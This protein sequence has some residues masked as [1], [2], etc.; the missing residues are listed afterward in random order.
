MMKI[1]DP[2][3]HLFDL[4]KGQYHWLKATN[5]PFWPDKSVIAKNFVEQDLHLASPLK[6]GGYVHIEAGFDNQQPWREIQWLEQNCQGNFRS[7]ASLD[8]TLAP[9]VFSQQL[10]KLLGY[11]S[12]VGIRHILDDDALTILNDKNS[13]YNLQQLAERKLSFELQLSLE[14]SKVINRL[15]EIIS[16]T[17]ALVYCINHAGWP[18][19]K[20]EKA[21]TN[22]LCWQ[23][24]IK[25]LSQFNNVYIK[26]S[27]YEMA[28]RQYS[29]QWQENI[30]AL[31]IASFG[32]SR[33]MLASNFPLS[34]WH[35]Q[36][37]QTWLNLINLQ[38][39]KNDLAKLCYNNA[40]DFYKFNQQD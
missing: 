33:V 22:S 11:Q 28:D 13:E 12:V 24:S 1:I 39:S 8:I 34:L 15:V 21:K 9:K 23:E 40:Y 31:C 10:D 37:Q 27:G 3:L 35:S 30:I 36:Y 14:N 7:V 16:A 38:Y 20:L 26:C 29:R 18:P 2:H 6:L 4:N 25:K 32:I 5:P 19:L 17:P